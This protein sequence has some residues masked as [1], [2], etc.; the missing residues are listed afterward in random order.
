MYRYHGHTQMWNEADNNDTLEQQQ[1][2]KREIF[3]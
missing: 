1:N 3:N 2:P